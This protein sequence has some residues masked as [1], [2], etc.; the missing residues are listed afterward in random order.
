MHRSV[1]VYAKKFSQRCGRFGK[2]I[3]ITIVVSEN[4]FIRRIFSILVDKAVWPLIFAE[5]FIG[6][7]SKHSICN[8]YF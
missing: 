7:A 2:T 4:I 6:E 3:H 8:I 1:C 5:Q